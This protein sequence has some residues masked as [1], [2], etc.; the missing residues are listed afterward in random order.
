VRATA[1]RNAAAGTLSPAHFHPDWKR[2]G[3]WFA[4]NFVTLIRLV[5][6]A[7]VILL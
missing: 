7:R 5:I 3:R 2:P 4:S 6:P 1:D